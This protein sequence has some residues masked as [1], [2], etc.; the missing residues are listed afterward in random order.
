MLITRSGSDGWHVGDRA[1]ARYLTAAAHR[2]GG[3]VWPVHRAN[4]REL[5][6][7]PA[8]EVAGPESA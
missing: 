8:V 7:V 6:A 5:V 3:T 2:V 1:W 4:D